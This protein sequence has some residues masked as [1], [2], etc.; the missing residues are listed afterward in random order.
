MI[1]ISLKGVLNTQQDFLGVLA[2]AWEED[3]KYVHLCSHF[4]LTT[5]HLRLT[6]MLVN[7]DEMF[8]E[9]EPIFAQIAENLGAHPQTLVD[10]VLVLPN[11]DALDVYLYIYQ[12]V[13]LCLYF[14]LMRLDTQD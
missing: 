7:I 4:N 10:S 1:L 9:M 12:Y 14:P 5:Q 13:Q 6:S 11:E 8:S 2:D 3:R